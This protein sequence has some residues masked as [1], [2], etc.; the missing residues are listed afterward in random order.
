[1]KKHD[2]ESYADW[3]KQYNIKNWERI[4][5]TYHPIEREKRRQQGVRQWYSNQRKKEQR[6][7]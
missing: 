5:E 4:Y 3:A 7:G 6:K 2:G 1:M